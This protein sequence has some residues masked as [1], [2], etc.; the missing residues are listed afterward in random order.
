MRVHEGTVLG[1][2]QRWRGSPPPQ[3]DV[4]IYCDDLLAERLAD[5]LLDLRLRE[6]SWSVA[7]ICVAFSDPVIW[8]YGLRPAAAY[9]A[10]AAMRA[11]RRSVASAPFVASLNSLQLPVGFAGD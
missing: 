11:F 9:E 7:E 5:P 2:M 4:A 6:H 8:H 10:A 1:R 3:V